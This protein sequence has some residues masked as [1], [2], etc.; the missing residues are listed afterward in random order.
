MPI[1][2]TKEK[3]GNWAIVMLDTK[4]I[5]VSI[6]HTPG[7]HISIYTTW[8]VINDLIYSLWFM[9]RHTTVVSYWWIV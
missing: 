1:N 8:N 3:N 2:L 6:I 7:I 5:P 4:Q 9:F